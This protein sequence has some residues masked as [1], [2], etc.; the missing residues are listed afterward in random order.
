M[1]TGSGTGTPATGAGTFTLSDL[2]GRIRDQ[3]E[4]ASGQTEPLVVTASSIQLTS[5]TPNLR[6]RVESILQDA[7]HSRWS[8][9]DLD[10]SIR[11]AL[12][13]FSNYN[14]HHAIGTIALSADG[15]EIDISSLTGLVRV[16]K[17]WW[18]YDSTTP[19]YPPKFRQ[20]EVWPGSILY[21]DDE[22]Q[23]SNGDT[24]RVWYTLMHTVK[25]LDSAT[26]TTIS[27]ED[28]AYL[29]SGAC[30]FAAQSRAVELSESLN[31]D[32]KVV[33]RLNDWAKEQGKNFRYGARADLPAWQRR[34]Y[35]F[36]Q[37]DIDEAIRWALGRYNETQPDETI[38]TITLS[39]SGREIDISSITDYLRITQVWFPYD[40]SDPGYHP[41]WVHYKTWPGDILFIDQ[42]TEPASGEVVRIWY[43]REHSIN[44]LDGGSAT[45]VHE[46]VET[47]LVTG[48]SGFVAQER[49]QEMPGTRVPTRLRE[50]A[51]ARL[52][53]FERGLKALAK[54]EAGQ[55]SG[56]A[57]TVALDRWD[58]GSW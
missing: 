44:G 53:E 4:A 32:S 36:N 54:R 14:P 1:A 19:G 11:R 5:G 56:I 27:V 37:D 55:H 16:E 40:S 21:I 39:S 31:V 22:T 46:D 45:T 25:G 2:R 20:F 18:D 41:N 23:P 47:L 38:T 29:I 48:A 50:W 30:H 8:T 49:V 42:S 17:V 6:A 24:V 57:E 58:T 35:A 13:Q 12:E 43:E 15:R 9:D 51:D 33:D 28:L 26:A 10:E 3:I 34:A 52:R 7:G